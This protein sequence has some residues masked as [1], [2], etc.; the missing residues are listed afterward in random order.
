MSLNAFLKSLNTAY[1]MKV[2]HVHDVN[3]YMDLNRILSPAES[4]G[5]LSRCPILY[6]TF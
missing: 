2:T 5:N 3:C 6:V 1:G 4:S